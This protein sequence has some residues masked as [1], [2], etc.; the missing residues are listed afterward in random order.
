LSRLSLYRRPSKE[1]APPSPLPLPWWGTGAGSSSQSWGREV[2]NTVAKI[3]L[4]TFKEENVFRTRNTCIG[5]SLPGWWVSK[6]E[7]F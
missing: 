7:Y 3:R 4:Q 1:M 2:R 5:L 6:P